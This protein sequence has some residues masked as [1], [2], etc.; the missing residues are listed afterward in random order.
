MKNRAVLSLLVASMLLSACAPTATPATVDQSATEATAS[1]NDRK[2]ETADIVITNANV[3]TEDVSNP[4]ANCIAIRD[5]KFIYVGDSDAPEVER[6]ISTSTQ[7][8]DAKGKFITPS[9][10]DAHTHITTPAMTEWCTEVYSEDR[11]ELFQQIRDGL[12]ET[13]DPYVMIKCY[14][15]DMF[16]EEGPRKEWLDEIDD[17]R[18]IAV[19]D[20]NDHSA[21][22]NSKF[23]EVMEG[24]LAK[25][26]KTLADIGAKRDKNGEYTGLIEELAFMDYMDEF[27]EVIGWRPPIDADEHLMSLV[28][29]KL[30]SW[31]EDGVFDAY[32]ESEQQVESISNM[33]KEGKLN[34]YYDL[35][36]KVPTY[37]DLDDCI[38]TAHEYQDK[39]GT[40]N[41]KIDTL[42]IFYDGTNELGTS[43]LVDGTVQNPNYHGEDHMFC[44]A[45]ETYEMIKKANDA[46]LDIHFHLVGDLAFRMVC[47][48]VE[49]LK[50]EIGDLDIQVEVCHCEYTNPVDRERPA[51]LGI[52]VNWTPQ[53]SGGYFGDGAKKYLGEERFND[54]YQFNE[55]IDSGAT[56]TYGS[57]IYSWDEVERANPYYGMQTAMTKKDLDD[58]FTD[59]DG[60]PIARPSE[61]ARLSL[62]DLLKGYTIDAAVQLRVDDHTGSITVGKDA[63]F[64]IYDKNLF[65][66]PA[67]EFKDVLPSAH[68]H[69]GVSQPVAKPNVEGEES[70]NAADELAQ[71]FDVEAVETMLANGKPSHAVESTISA[72]MEAHPECTY[73]YLINKDEE[74][75]VQFL[76]NWEDTDEYWG[77]EFESYDEPEQAFAGES[78]VDSEPTTD[79]DGTVLTAYSPIKSADGEVIAVACVDTAVEPEQKA[80]TVYKNG[81]FTTGNEEEPAAEAYAVCNGKV[82]YVGLDNTQSLAYLVGADTEVIDCKGAEIDGHIIFGEEPIINE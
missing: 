52:I 66:V 63:N 65:D 30:K 24:V 43:A 16:G 44:N 13:D 47:D 69:K 51:K 12:A 77:N 74:G 17:S 14:P 1:T 34:M 71:M 64:N 28:T 25:H 26:D 49:K 61:S 23:L 54:M 29:D 55:M 50:N 46:K 9:L 76:C 81:K 31:G 38:E 59:E 37:A 82:C 22:V 73:A 21:W 5:G 19:S 60:N 15:S 35:A 2:E 53:W 33:D 70:A 4:S 10:I 36:V 72:Y 42:K 68:Y 67:D 79:K 39:Y 45:D 57:D 75:N 56:V 8:I 41:V 20:F 18:P 6:L 48:A 58:S 62:E 7:V 11:D 78:A 3:Y 27:Y 32:I 40:D 80:D